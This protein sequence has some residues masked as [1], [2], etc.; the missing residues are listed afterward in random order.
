M[1]SAYDQ[2][3]T[4][5]SA[6]ISFCIFKCIRFLDIWK[7]KKGGPFSPT[8]VQVEKQLKTRR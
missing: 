3:S 6:P 4:S 1:I 8:I 2:A 5:D 7:D